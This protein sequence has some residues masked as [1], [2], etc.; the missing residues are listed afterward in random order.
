MSQ[1]LIVEDD[2]N[3]AALFEEYLKDEPY[4]LTTV[5]DGADALNALN[6]TSFSAVLLDLKLPDMD[7]FDI[8]KHINEK[9]MGCAVIVITGQGSMN[10]A[11]DA[12]RLGAKDFLMK[13]T[14]KDRL[15]ITLRNA[16]DSLEMQ[17]IIQTYQKKIDR[18]DYCGFIGSSLPMQEVYRIIDSAAGSKATV[19][20]TGESGTGKEVCAEA[21][22]KKSNRK[23]KPFCA[24]N[25]AAIPR[26]LMESEIFGHV[27]G[28]FTGANADRD[29]AASKADG[30]TLFL[31]E[32]GEMDLDLQTKILRF[33]QTGKFM[34]VG[35]SQEINVDVRIICAT[36]CDPLEEVK[37]GRFR[38]DLYYR[39]HVLPIEMPPL[40]ERDDDIIQIAEF[41]LKT[42]AAE[43]N[44]NF[45]GFDEDVQ[46]IFRIYDWPGNVRQLQN[47]VRNVVV[48][49]DAETVSLNLL[50]APLNNINPASAP[51]I[52][53][54]Q[55]Q[56]QSSSVIVQQ[57]VTQKDSPDSLLGK[58][59][60]TLVRIEELE[61]MAI[62]NAIHVCDGNIPE[63]AHYL[64]VSAATI[65]RKKSAWEK[66]EHANT[67]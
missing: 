55:T 30:G 27:K 51:P 37:A 11:I 58:T 63:V 17:E 10:T 25:C 43:E 15:I 57:S 18:H 2:K 54:K 39:L 24:I 59:P 8:L 66:V 28:A 12:M 65:Y 1:I 45:K 41:F 32:I 46:S 61:R 31:D 34:K 62:E 38:E 23:G 6:N 53:P 33:V 36:N 19:F 16:L 50:P 49:N 21:I 47:V 64:G 22:H 29:G 35:R 5:K 40:R 3:M 67:A 44:K 7:G 13:P 9:A 60:E 48:L 4:Q 20:I 52:R 56:L 42:H 14:G 26:D